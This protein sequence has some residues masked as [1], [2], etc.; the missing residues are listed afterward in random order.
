MKYGIVV[1][2]E[3]IFMWMVFDF[4]F[5]QMNHQEL[6]QTTRLQHNYFSICAVLTWKDWIAI[7][8]NLLDFQIFYSLVTLSFYMNLNLETDFLIKVKPQGYLRSWLVEILVTVQRTHRWNL[9]NNYV[10][11]LIICWKMKIFNHFLNI[12]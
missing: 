4:S 8:T 9:I 1:R 7:E 11:T 3:F 12:F 5:N 10:S 6:L 2:F